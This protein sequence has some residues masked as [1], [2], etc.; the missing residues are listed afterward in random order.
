MN[1][2]ILPE[3]NYTS[4]LNGSSKGIQVKGESFSRIQ[5]HAEELLSK[6]LESKVDKEIEKYQREIQG[7]INRGQD[8]SDRGYANRNDVAPTAT[9]SSTISDNIIT[10]PTEKTYIG[11]KNKP[12]KLVPTMLRVVDANYKLDMHKM[13]ANSHSQNPNNKVEVSLPTAEITTI[14]RKSIFDSTPQLEVTQPTQNKVVEFNREKP[15]RSSRRPILNV[16]ERSISAFD[17]QSNKPRIAE[18]QV[19]DHKIISITDKIKE[20]KKSSIF[21]TVPSPSVSMT[22]DDVVMQTTQ[23]VEQ[24]ER[25]TRKLEEALREQ[26]EI[27]RQ[28]QEM[29]LRFQQAYEN[30]KKET[31][32]TIARADEVNKNIHNTREDT[33]KYEAAIERIER[34][35]K[36]NDNQEEPRKMAM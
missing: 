19:D 8:Y 9:Q 26:Q 13:N 16:A 15:L 18:K 31:I 4:V 28:N 23:I 1:D 33:E 7:L 24:N 25:E 21:D 2:L 20:N 17:M 34:M 29:R 3:I 27:E 10:F 36:G 35:L 6:N 14:E 30:M 12:L 11:V 22:V 32:A 5:R